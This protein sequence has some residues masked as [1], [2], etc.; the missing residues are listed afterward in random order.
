M[1]FIFTM[2]IAMVAGS[3]VVEWIL[4]QKLKD[5][6]GAGI[7]WMMMAVTMLFLGVSTIGLIW[8]GYQNFI[9]PVAT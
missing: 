1:Q 2:M 3:I 4:P 7:C 6:L 5:T 9:A 8:M